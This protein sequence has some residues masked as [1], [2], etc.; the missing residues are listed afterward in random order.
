MFAALEIYFVLLALSASLGFAAIFLSEKHKTFKDSLNATLESFATAIGL[1]LVAAITATQAPNV[2]ITKFFGDGVGRLALVNMPFIIYMAFAAVSTALS[3]V[4]IEYRHLTRWG[5]GLAAFEIASLCLIRHFSLP[6]TMFF[7]L[8][9]GLLSGYTLSALENK[10]D[11]RRTACRDAECR[12]SGALGFAAAGIAVLSAAIFSAI[13]WGGAYGVSLAAMGVLG[14]KVSGKPAATSY[15]RAGSA[16]SNAALFLVFVR[17]LEFI[18]RRDASLDI[19]DAQVV[20]GL[21]LSGATVLLI[22]QKTINAVRR[23]ESGEA[24]AKRGFIY[25][26][27]VVAFMTMGLPFIKWELLLAVALGVM[28]LSPI[29][30]L[31]MVAMPGAGEKTRVVA[32]L[33]AQITTLLIVGTILLLPMLKG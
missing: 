33:Y 2:H 32:P 27:G 11:S 24:V 7:A 12:V 28:V 20:I 15:K 8:S 9:L 13:S 30:G 4:K 31:L 3:F 10:M 22:L 5:V 16:I 14:A 25:C 21:F 1:V 23:I 6:S 26:A 19:S 29:V 17:T 18:I